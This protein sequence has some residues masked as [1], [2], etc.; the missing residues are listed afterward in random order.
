[1]YKSRK[2]K[3]FYSNFEYAG[4]LPNRVSERVVSNRLFV[5]DVFLS[6]LPYKFYVSTMDY[7]MFV[8]LVLLNLDTNRICAPKFYYLVRCPYIS[9]RQI[10]DITEFQKENS[11]CM[12]LV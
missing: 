2:R 4:T 3:K 12:K 5:R 6:V 10:Y 7:S 11:Y 8:E 9:L 1:M